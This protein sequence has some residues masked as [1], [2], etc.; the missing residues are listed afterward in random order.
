MKEEKVK[1]RG[2]PRMKRVSNKIISDELII[3]R[4]KC[5]WNVGRGRWCE[6]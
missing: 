3:V 1:E 4:K 6:E 2:M 5:D